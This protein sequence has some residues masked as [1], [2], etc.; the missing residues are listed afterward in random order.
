MKTVLARAARL[1]ARMAR[2]LR[3]LHPMFARPNDAWAKAKL[4][5][6]EYS[7]YARMDARDR[8]HAVRVAQKLLQLQP[9]SNPL[10]VRAAILH[11]CGKQVR[12]Y[13][14]V[15]RVLVGLVNE[16]PSNEMILNPE[17]KLSA[18]EVRQHHASIGA[19]L[20]RDAGGDARVATI[21]ERHH[22]PSGDTDAELI[23]TVDELE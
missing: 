13:S 16:K 12:P 5:P 15:E 22:A 1:L 3:A 23:H 17:K 14:V 21:V 8:E 2:L 19:N 6:E 7:V 18:Q 9:N 20:I 4:S 11:D 10:V